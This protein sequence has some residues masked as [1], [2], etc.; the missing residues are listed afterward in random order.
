MDLE[1]PVDPMS[2]DLTEGHTAAQ[3]EL[4]DLALVELNV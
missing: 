2:V 4:A 1:D 3:S